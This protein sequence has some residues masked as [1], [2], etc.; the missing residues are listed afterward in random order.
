MSLPGLLLTKASSK[1]QE[2]TGSLKFSLCNSEFS[3]FDMVPSCRHGRAWD[4]NTM[5]LQYILNVQPDNSACLLLKLPLYSRQCSNSSDRQADVLNPCAGR[6]MD[7]Y[8]SSI[9]KC[10]E[11]KCSL[12][13]PFSDFLR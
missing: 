7:T 10:P 1:F 5:C 11:I 12:S 8:R 9:I 2:L 3:P 6:C 13:G 4:Y